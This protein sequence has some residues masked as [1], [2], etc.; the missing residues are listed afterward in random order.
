MHKFSVKKKNRKSAKPVGHISIAHDVAHKDC[1]SRETKGETIGNC[2]TKTRGDFKR[3]GE[4]QAA[5]LLSP[6]R[7]GKSG[8]TR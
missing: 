2:E 4:K 6:R 1:T 7:G 3:R 5:G 8:V